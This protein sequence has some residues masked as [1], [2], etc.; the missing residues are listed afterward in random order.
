MKIDIF[1]MIG[2]RHPSLGTWRLLVQGRIYRNAPPSF[3]K[4]LML[5]GLQRALRTTGESVTSDLFRSRIEGFLAAAEPSKRLHAEIDGVG[6]Q[7]KRKSKSS[8]MYYSKLDLPEGVIRGALSTAGGSGYATLS[9]KFRVI[10]VDSAET[11]AHAFLA[12]PR[13]LSIVSD[14]DDTIKNTLVCSRREML[15]QTFLRPFEAIEGMADL[16]RHWQSQGAMFHYVS[17]SPWQIFS[18]LAGFLDDNRFPSGSMHLRWFRL[19]DE[20]FKRW[21]M[22]RRKGKG[23]II[24]SLVKRLPERSFLLVGDSGER[25]PEIYAKIAARFPDQ[26]PAIVIRDLDEKPMEG[27]RLRRLNRKL[28]GVPLILFREANE[29]TDVVESLKASMKL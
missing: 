27:N 5:S 2:Y 12:S 9:L 10:G 28:P 23:G 3:G 6:F 17:S 19:R 11:Q 7:L 8:G 25:D 16:Y 26:V 22:M 4:R 21:R 18:P 15:A 29:L 1:P 24:V 20:M 13:G 14:I